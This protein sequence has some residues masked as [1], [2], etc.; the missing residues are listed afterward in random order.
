MRV[1]LDACVLYPTILR[2]ILL[3]VALAG[4]FEPLWS[5]RILEEW[6]RAAARD[7]ASPNGVDAALVRDKWPGAMV[8]PDA[9]LMATLSLPD[10]DDVHVLATAIIGRADAL[11]TF[12]LR[13]F[14]TRV[15]ARHGVL[16]RDPDGFLTE[17]AAETSDVAMAAEA[18]R[19]TAE[20]LSG[21]PQALKPLL[22]RVGVPRL[23]RALA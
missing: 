9:D 8:A 16:R 22:R 15:L 10:P 2:E 5:A 14:P 12:N 11:L 23:S 3:S 19:H 1:V 6:T 4:H 20:R 7:G 17:L 13:D 21:K 18:S